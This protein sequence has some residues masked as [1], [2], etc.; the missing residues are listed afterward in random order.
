M[1]AG[2]DN[3]PAQDSAEKVCRQ[4]TFTR[5]GLTFSYGGTLFNSA[6]DRP[7]W[8]TQE[9]GWILGWLLARMLIRQPV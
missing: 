4:K 9:P 6:Q 7:P 2:S 3:T 8:R 1:G 5:E